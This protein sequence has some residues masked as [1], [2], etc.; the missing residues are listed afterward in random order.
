MNFNLKKFI[1]YIAILTSFVWLGIVAFKS[2]GL[3]E[4]YKAYKFKREICTIYYLNLCKN[5]SN[6]IDVCKNWETFDKKEQELLKF[7]NKYKLKSPDLIPL[8][9]ENIEIKNDLKDCSSE[10]KSIIFEKYKILNYMLIQKLKLLFLGLLPIW[11]ITLFIYFFINF[12]KKY[13]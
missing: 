5:K 2:Q 10:G 4:A 13:L 12:R 6:K 11:S 9:L 7:S 8:L 1:I 3:W